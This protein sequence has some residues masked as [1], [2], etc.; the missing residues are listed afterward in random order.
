M[1]VDRL[2]RHSVE[3]G[4]LQP[5]GRNNG[6]ELSGKM[7]PRPGTLLRGRSVLSDLQANDGLDRIAPVLQG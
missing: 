5:T 2:D 7:G 6:V 4:Q 1:T 3:E